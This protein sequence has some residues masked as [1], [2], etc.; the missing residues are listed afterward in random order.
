MNDDA[1]VM[2]KDHTKEVMSVTDW[3]ITIFIY[4]IPIVGFVMLFVWAFGGGG[5]KNRANM[6]KALLIWIVIL[7]AFATV[8]FLLFG[9]TL[10]SMYSMS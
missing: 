4:A 10:L 7:M 2:M 8:M 1:T 9:A 5:N 6:A 3:L